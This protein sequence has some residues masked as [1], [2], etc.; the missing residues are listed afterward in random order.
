MAQ[1]GAAPAERAAPPAAP[2]AEP[3]GPEDIVL[4]GTFD[5]T[6]EEGFRNLPDKFRVF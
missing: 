4:E 3:S 6:V 5:A 2:P 1:P